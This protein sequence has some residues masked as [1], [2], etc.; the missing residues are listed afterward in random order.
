MLQWKSNR[1]T[2]PRQMFFQPIRKF[3]APILVVTF[4][5]KWNVVEDT[6]GT[7]VIGR[8]VHQSKFQATFHCCHAHCSPEPQLNI[9]DQTQ[10]QNNFTWNSLQHITLR[11]LPFSQSLS[12]SVGESSLAMWGNPHSQHSPLHPWLTHAYQ[13][14]SNMHGMNPWVRVW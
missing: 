8:L 13:C 7:F 9:S 6:T 5:P 12:Q 4:G 2:E 14:E 10:P 11:F 3:T 1:V